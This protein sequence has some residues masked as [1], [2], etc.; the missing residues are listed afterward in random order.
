MLRR[1]AFRRSTTPRRPCLH[2]PARVAVRCVC[3]EMRRSHGCAL[4]Y[5]WC[6]RKRRERNVCFLLLKNCSSVLSS[7]QRFNASIKSMD[8]AHSHSLIA[9]VRVPCGLGALSEINDK[10]RGGGRGTEPHFQHHTL[11]TPTCAQ[12][13]VNPRGEKTPLKITKPLSQISADIACTGV[14]AS[15]HTHATVGSV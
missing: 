6:A 12:Q 13:L 7:R 3:V 2:R 4:S 10:Y 11:R 14:H 5:C 1:A 8:H 9:H 15:T